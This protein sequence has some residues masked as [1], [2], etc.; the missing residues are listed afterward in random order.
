MSDEASFAS[1][2]AMPAPRK[3]ERLSGVKGMNDL[4]P[5]DSDAGSEVAPRPVYALLGN[6]QMRAS[7]K[8]RALQA[9]HEHIFRA[10]RAEDWKKARA[11]I[12]QCRALSGANERLYE[13]YLKR[14]A[15]LETHPPEHGWDGVFRP[16]AF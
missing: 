7:P 13:T 11:L 1:D 6:P 10:Y 5:G 8:F 3:A 15:F 4:L 9:F 16:P 2:S 12:E 14:I